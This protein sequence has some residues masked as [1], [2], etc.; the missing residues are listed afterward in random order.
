MRN[1]IGRLNAR[2]Q[3]DLDRIAVA[4]RMVITAPDKA[5]TV[6]QVIRTLTDIRAVRDAW[7]SLD[8][9]DR[10]LLAVLSE[11][12][13]PMA[14]ESIAAATKTNEAD[15]RSA[16]IRLYRSGWIARDGDNSELRIDEMPRLFVPPELAGAIVRVRSELSAG[17]RAL[18]PLTEL[19]SELDN[20]EL[21][22][23]AQQWGLAVLPGLRSRD[24]LIALITTAV[25]EPGATE[26]L[27]KRLDP[28]DALLYQ[29]VREGP[30]DGVPLAEALE[31]AR[32][33]LDAPGG[34]LR[35]RALLGRL[36]RSLLVWHGYDWKGERLLF[37]P[38][39][40]R[41]P[42]AKG[43]IEPPTAIHLSDSA[44]IAAYH[45]HLAWDLLTLLRGLTAT[46]RPR[47]RPGD[48]FPGGFLERLNRRFWHHGGE[49]PPDGY[50]P[51]LTAL[52]QSEG[53]IVPEDGRG[54][55]TVASD[56]RT[57]RDRSFE[58][59]DARLRLRWLTAIDWIEGSEQSAIQI[60][61]A[62]WRT[63]RRT[64]L[65]A[66]ADIPDNEWRPLDLVAT[67]IIERDPGLLGRAYTVAVGVGIDDEGAEGRRNAALAV[68][69]ITLRRA[70]VWLGLIETRRAAAHEFV[71][72]VTPRGRAVATGK[73]LDRE[74]NLPIMTLAN[75]G[76]LTLDHPHPLQIWSLSAFTDQLELGPPAR[77]RLSARSIDRA[78]EAGF[79]ASQI[80]SFLRNQTRMDLPV[81]IA[82]LLEKEQRQHPIVQF[83]AATLVTPTSEHARNELTRVLTAA[84]IQFRELGADIMIRSSSAD[85]EKL[86][87]MLR[88]GGF[89]VRDGP[90]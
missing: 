71:M 58:D 35:A 72:R 4:W 48:P 18:A 23:A 42:H 16:A 29:V 61:G 86:H 64:L 15:T 84:G 1:L 90:R 26:W 25:G 11:A 41:S 81:E 85:A 78:I 17:N 20:V 45:Y 5:G 22:S 34:H 12:R 21:E 6:A 43:P 31:R 74:Q 3:T 37:I 27:V 49:R 14:I 40:I 89:V 67:W 52:A 68:I 9:N 59:Q 47:T 10:A 8:D 7:W 36:E 2:S 77:Y 76:T 70:F 38:V 60:W 24:E 80:A 88:S 39:D 56:I 30:D 19:L 32:I 28:D 63:M 65:E 79:Q 46:D 62:D 55:I 69:T 53:L 54:P 87:T 13:E 82:S 83:E 50:V 44:P 75:G 73:A 57:W 66:I 51:F 33:D